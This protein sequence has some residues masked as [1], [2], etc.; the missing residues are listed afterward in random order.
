M[1]SGVLRRGIASLCFTEALSRDGC[2][3]ATIVADP[4]H[5][6]KIYSLSGPTLAR[7]AILPHRSLK[8]FLCRLKTTALA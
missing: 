6:L 1:N 5:F 7:A 3:A 4:Q 8:S 2:S